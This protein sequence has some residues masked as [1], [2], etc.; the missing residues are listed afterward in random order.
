MVQGT[1][2][3]LSRFQ[4]PEVRTR[5]VPD[6]DTVFLGMSCPSRRKT[7]GLDAACCLALFPGHWQALRKVIE[8]EI[9]M[10]AK[11]FVISILAHKSCAKIA[12]RE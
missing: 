5:E 12:F 4:A 10:T 11:V 8:N 7:Q 9:T 2:R 1:L 6:N 3:N